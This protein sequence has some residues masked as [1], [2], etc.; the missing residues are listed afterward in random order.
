MLEHTIQYPRND[1]FDEIEMELFIS[2]QTK[3]LK[4]SYQ[5]CIAAV[6]ASA[7]EQLVVGTKALSALVQAS[8]F[9]TTVTA[10]GASKVKAR[11]RYRANKEPAIG[12]T[13][14]ML[15]LTI[16]DSSNLGAGIMDSV[17]AKSSMICRSKSS[18][19][20]NKT[21]GCDP[22]DA[23][24]VPKVGEKC[25]TR[26][27]SANPARNNT[28]ADTVRVADS[29]AVDCASLQISVS[30][31]ETELPKAIQPSESNTVSS[32]SHLILP[33]ATA[34]YQTRGNPQGKAAYSARMN[35]ISTVS[36]YAALGIENYPF[37]CLRTYGSQC[38]VIM[39][40]K[41]TK[42]DRIYLMERNICSFDISSP[43]QA[44]QFAGFLLRLRD[45]R[46]ELKALVQD[47]MDEGV[48][49]QKMIWWRKGTQAQESE[50][51][52]STT[53]AIEQ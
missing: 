23:E 43:G 7:D 15:F 14:A 33:H 34:Q 8:E 30:A 16:S 11:L 5:L 20:A 27:E 4:Q 21:D 49:F 38:S 40:W 1:L 46:E 25:R 31:Y 50:L 35:L 12:K 37:Y 28:S 26:V 36:F 47:K 13:D 39:A 9:R 53:F 17:N 51:K 41:S 22:I 42:K 2:E 44:F 10:W 3:R 45:D 19:A 18:F 24:R 52:K 32:E 48:D 6:S 29:S